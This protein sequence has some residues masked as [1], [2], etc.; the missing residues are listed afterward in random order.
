MPVTAEVTSL[1]SL[2]KLLFIKVMDEVQ[3]KQISLCSWWLQA[4]VALT[5]NLVSIYQKLL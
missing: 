5:G 1:C 2:E 3:Y 4:E